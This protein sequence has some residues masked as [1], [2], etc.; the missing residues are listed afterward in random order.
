M[1]RA[2]AYI[3]VSTARQELSPEAQVERIRQFAAFNGY[4]LPDDRIIVDIA[5]SGR[6]RFE[7]RELGKKA[8]ELLDGADVIIFA[9]LSRAF[10]NAAD[11]MTLVP[12]LLAKGKDVAFLDLGCSVS[13]TT[14]KMI[15]GML[16]VLAEWEADIIAERTK[17]CLDH[18]AKQGKKLGGVPYGSR[19]AVK[20]V[21]GKRVDAG[22]HVPDA[23]ELRVI[24]QIRLMRSYPKP[25]AYRKIA[26]VLEAE[27]V[28]TRRKGVWQGETVRKIARRT[29]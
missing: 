25:M 20:V 22:V 14:G 15:M 21:D 5:T 28:P 2:V 29:P 9:K 17:E 23:D 13:T 16:A 4:D 24:A 11:A 3:R 8:L 7:A 19:P 6:K 1:I 18:A 10:R 12:Q 27:G 26:A